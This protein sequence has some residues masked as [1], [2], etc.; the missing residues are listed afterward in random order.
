MKRHGVLLAVDMP[1]FCGHLVGDCKDIDFWVC[2]VVCKDTHLRVPKDTESRDRVD[3]VFERRDDIHDLLCVCHVTSFADRVEGGPGG[4]DWTSRAC[5][6]EARRGVDAARPIRLY[7][8]LMF[9]I[10]HTSIQDHRSAFRSVSVFVDVGRDRGYAGHAK[11]K[12]RDRVAELLDEGEQKA[13][14]ATVDVKGEFLFQ[15][16]RTKFGDRVDDT[17]WIAWG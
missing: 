3:T 14:E 6:C 15:R 11:V 4:C 17:M 5:P 8:E 1:A 7:K 13:A 10:V 12:G 16:E 9:E 2:G